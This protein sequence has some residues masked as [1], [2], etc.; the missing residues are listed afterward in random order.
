M[1]SPSSW[2][3]LSH[4]NPFIQTNDNQMELSLD[5]MLDEAVHP[6]SVSVELPL[7]KWQCEDEHYLGGRKLNP[8]SFFAL[9]VLRSSLFYSEEL[10]N[11][12]H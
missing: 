10:N 7:L 3:L 2:N 8:A 5:C 1:T 9:S 4:K 12:V 6:T 11:T